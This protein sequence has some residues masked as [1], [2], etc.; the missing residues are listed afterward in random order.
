[1][2]QLSGVHAA[3]SVSVCSS[4][5]EGAESLVAVCT[6]IKGLHRAPRKYQGFRGP[7]SPRVTTEPLH[8]LAK[9]ID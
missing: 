1:M 8:H 6:I 2:G 9:P 5:S 4:P 7:G 3:G